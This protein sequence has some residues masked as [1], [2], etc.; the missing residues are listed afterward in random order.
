MATATARAQADTPSAVAAVTHTISHKPVS[1][2]AANLMFAVA[3]NTS[4]GGLRTRSYCR[5][6]AGHA[7]AGSPSLATPATLARD[8]PQNGTP[9]GSRNLYDAP[10]CRSIAAWQ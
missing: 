5:S 3:R 10:R 7:T 6:R 9:S 1:V 4:L 2:T 8:P